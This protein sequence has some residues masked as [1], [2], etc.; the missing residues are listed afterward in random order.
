MKGADGGRIR[1]LGWGWEE[2]RGLLESPFEA[3]GHL[4]L[5]RFRGCAV[6]RLVACRP[7][8]AEQAQVAEVEME[9]AESP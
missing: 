7:F 4:E 9:L 1:C 3:L 2:K 5:D 6:F 8:V